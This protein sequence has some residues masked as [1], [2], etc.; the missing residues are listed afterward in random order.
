[1]YSFAT[2]KNENVKTPIFPIS[3][4]LSS[5][6]HFCWYFLSYWKLLFVSYIFIFKSYTEIYFL[7]YPYANQQ[8]VF[9][10]DVVIVISCYVTLVSLKEKINVSWLW[11]GYALTLCGDIWGVGGSLITV[12]NRRF[13]IKPMLMMIKQTKKITLWRCWLYLFAGFTYSR[14][15]EM[16][17]ISSFFKP[18]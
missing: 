7:V 9:S 16:E 11:E 18:I 15:L 4:I 12:I 1:M 3:S 5:T 8:N 2:L 10:F 17:T 6:S 14:I 13:E